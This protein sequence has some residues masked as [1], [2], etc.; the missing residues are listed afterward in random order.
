MGADSRLRQRTQIFLDYLRLP[1][2]KAPKLLEAFQH[3]LDLMELYK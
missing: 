3:G 1:E 2:R